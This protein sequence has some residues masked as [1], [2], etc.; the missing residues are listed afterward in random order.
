MTSADIPR[1]G[2]TLLLLGLGGLS[3]YS[4]QAISD[5][6]FEKSMPRW[7]IRLLFLFS[8][9]SIVMFLVAL[10]SAPPAEQMKSLAAILCGAAGAFVSGAVVGFIFGIPRAVQV[11]VT[12]GGSGHIS[13]SS[14]TPNTNLERVSEWLTGIIVGLTLVQFDRIR[15]YFLFAARSL[16]A[17]LGQQ[18]IFFA[19]ALLIFFSL[20]GFLTA[21]LWTRLRLIGDLNRADDVAQREPEYLEGLMH[22]FLYTPAPNG[23]SQAIHYGLEYQQQFKVFN[24]RVLIYLSCAYGQQYRYRKAKGPESGKEKSVEE[25]PELARLAALDAIRTCLQS[26]PSSYKMLHALW[27]PSEAG[28]GEDD[29]VVFFDDPEFKA[30]FDE[31]ARR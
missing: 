23:F 16:M 26:D 20:A 2:V 17:A 24:P 6:N 19:A 30:V 21:Y 18:E 27:D 4:L 29:L 11:Q 9:I 3:L 8:L 1:I 15:H 13:Q 25:T 31:H 12:G 10:F 22:A 28:P 7:L 14:Y 5:D